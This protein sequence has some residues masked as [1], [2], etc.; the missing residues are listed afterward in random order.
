MT[1]IVEFPLNQRQQK[2]CPYQNKERC[3]NVIEIVIKKCSNHPVKTELEDCL[4]DGRNT[5]DQKKD[6]YM[7]SCFFI[8]HLI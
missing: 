3:Q 7:R 4:I 2:V 5:N 1:M 6:R 8:K